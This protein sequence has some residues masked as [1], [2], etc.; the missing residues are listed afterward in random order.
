[1]TIEKKLEEL[2]KIIPLKFRVWS[3]AGTNF[4]VMWYIDARDCQDRL[5]D[6]FWLDRQR[7]YQDVWWKAYCTV[8]IWDWS[9][10]ISRSDVGDP[11]AISKNKW[12]S[13]DS[14]KRACVNWGLGRFLYTMPKIMISESEEKAN[15]RKITEFV[16]KKFQKELKEWAIQY[17]LDLESKSKYNSTDDETTELPDVNMDD[18]TSGFNSPTK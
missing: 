4:I 5:D 15:K 12:E 8:S 1:M 17:W 16:K 13:S 11:T 7:T 14:F 3:K 6:I 10:W 18:A 2:K 9:K